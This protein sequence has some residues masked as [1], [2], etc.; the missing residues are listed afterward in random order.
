MSWESANG[1]AKVL[2]SKEHS[3]T[4]L[5]IQNG[6]CNDALST[7][8]A[9]NTTLEQLHLHNTDSSPVMSFL[10][11]L[12]SQQL[13]TL[14]LYHLWNYSFINLVG[15][16]T[17]PNRNNK[18]WP[19]CLQQLVFDSMRPGVEII[20]KAFIQRFCYFLSRTKTNLLHVCF[21]LYSAEVRY[22]LPGELILPEEAKQAMDFPNDT[23]TE[24]DIDALLEKNRY[25]LR[26]WIKIAVLTVFAR[27]I[28]PAFPP[29]F[30]RSV[31]P[32]LPG[33]LALTR[34]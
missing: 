21:R 19:K 16:F 6:V 13:N 11:I 23:E 15:E 17:L 9:T 2:E 4:S 1:L 28:L 27:A 29:V 33:I 18:G 32:V 7:A 26:T 34:K 5:D 20:H 10:E 25:E 12:G 22:Y 24:P 8:L 14:S 31:L 3:L 30:M